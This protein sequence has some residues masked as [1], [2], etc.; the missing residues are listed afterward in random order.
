MD[1][2]IVSDLCE[3]GPIVYNRFDEPGGRSSRPREMRPS[4]QLAV[5][6][7]MTH[8]LGLWGLIDK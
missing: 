6:T 3:L 4:R 7:V 8:E 1:G 2:F 5:M